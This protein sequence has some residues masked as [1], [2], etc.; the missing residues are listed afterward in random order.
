MKTEIWQRT[1][2]SYYGGK[3]TMLKYILPLIPEHQIYTK[4]FFG[5]GAVFWAKEPSQ[6]EI[7][8]DFNANVYNFYQVLKTDFETL[9]TLVENSVISKEC[10]KSALVV[11]HSPYIFSPIQRAWAFWYATNFGFSNQIGNIRICN[12]P[13]YVNGLKNKIDRF[14][15]EYSA[16]LQ[17]TQ[18]END[19][20]CKIIKLRD[21]EDTFHYIDPPYVGANQG[22]YGGY[23]QEHFEELLI[24]LSQCKGKFLLSSY[25]NEAL[26]TFV[27]EFGWYQKEI[28]L[29]LGSSKTKGKKRVE[30]L[31]A[32]YPI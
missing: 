19:D 32:N 28:T 15:D 25:H 12:T 9:K 26:T 1:P 10:Y 17:H 27:K 4:A 16:R 2:I 29:H 21:T 5:G 30:V 14:V 8:N 6:T 11:Y 13:K 31:T 18:I 3:Q 23:T 24:T 20:A 22:H 7:I